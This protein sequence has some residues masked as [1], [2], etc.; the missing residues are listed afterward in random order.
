MLDVSA[1]FREAVVADRRRVLV[2]A[3]V[4][5]SDP[6][7]TFLPTQSSGQAVI[8]HPE[9]VHDKILTLGGPFATLEANRWLLD[10]EFSIM[11]DNPATIQEQVGFVGDALSGADGT[12]SPPVWVAERF[13]HVYVLQA[14]S[15]HFPEADFNGLADTFTVEVLEGGVVR[16]TETVTGNRAASVSF[17]G[18][19]VYNPD[20]I[21]VTVSKWSLPGHRIRVPEIVP[22]IYERWDGGD[23]AEVNVVQQGNVS[24]L[25]LPFGTCL[26]KMDNQDRRFEP[27]GKDGLF[28]SIEER[29]GIDIFLGVALG[30]GESEYKRVGIFYQSN[31]GWR[32]GSNDMTMQW[33]LVDIVGLLADR[34]FLPPDT[35]PTTLEGWLTAI[36]GQLG[37]NFAHRYIV[38]P[39]YAGLPVTASRDD[40]KDITCGELLR[41]V[42][43][44]TG[45]WPRADASSG[46]LTAEPLWSQGNTLDL[47]N[48]A[49]YPSIRA[50]DEVA[51]LLFTLSDGTEIVVAGTSAASP[52]TVSVKN[53]FIHTQA[54]ALAAARLILATYGGNQME[55][56]GRGN[57]SS[58]IGDVDTVWLTPST[59]STGRRIRQTFQF[60]QGVLQ[61]C[62]STLLQASGSFLFQASKLIT[63]S[64]TFTSP[65]GVRLLRVIIGQAGQGGGRG[66]DGYLST[67]GDSVI[68]GPG[69]M[70][71]P[72]WGGKIWYGEVP[73]NEEQAFT[74][75]IGQGGA[76]GTVYGAPGAEGEETT[77]GTYSS[78][79]GAFY[80]NGFTDVASGTSFGHTGVAVPAPNTGD[81]GAGGEGGEAGI[82]YMR[83]RTS[84]SG[85]SW[86]DFVKVKDPGPGQPGKQG[87]SGFV[88]VYWDKE[89]T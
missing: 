79:N 43:M 88:L 69:E 72:G 27:S 51:A 38:D 52:K 50:N 67:S 84:E 86:S 25:S 57:P 35:L 45:T 33:D 36:V 60:S 34:T 54:Q 66:H 13:A 77:F 19:T 8:S 74:V 42:C 85:M 71:L 44:A 22:G 32:T 81:G 29:Q 30:G 61:G 31:G 80:P 10:G 87:A 59:A 56:V 6:D 82:G 64:G 20:T 41:H 83:T 68:A 70:G 28:Q 16:Y 17:R 24:C 49:S 46:R 23:L 53:P 37:E 7:L 62:Q 39:A 18:F 5:I 75:H 73:C 3:V 12:F 58:E 47:D 11:P 26:L 4:D 21:R 14:C 15:V 78:A 48:L 55:T 76:P 9:E 2:R 63:E 1:A 40:I 89:A 65:P